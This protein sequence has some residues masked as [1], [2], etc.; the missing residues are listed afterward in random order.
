MISD[1]LTPYDLWLSYTA[2]DS[3]IANHLTLNKEIILTSV[4]SQSLQESLLV[5]DK[6]TEDTTAT[7]GFEDKCSGPQTKDDEQA[8]ETQNDRFCLESQRAAL[9][10][11]QP[12][13]RSNSD[14]RYPKLSTPSC[15]SL[16]LYGNLL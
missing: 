16:Q 3:T 2:N 7:S 13:F 11:S 10:C 4:G 8:L 14:V 15:R 12:D 1:I 5:E 6:E 9:P